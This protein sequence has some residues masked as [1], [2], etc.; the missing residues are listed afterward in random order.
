VLSAAG[1]RTARVDAQKGAD[2][3]EE[4]QDGAVRRLGASVLGLGYTAKSHAYGSAWYEHRP[5][6]GDG[7]FA[8]D[9]V[10]P[11][12]A[13]P[14]DEDEEAR[15]MVIR[16][17]CIF[18]GVSRAFFRERFGR[19]L[20]EH[21]ALA[22]GLSELESLGKISVSAETVVSRM[23]D[24]AERSVWLKALYSEKVIEGLL[25]LH[26]EEY[27][28]FVADEATLGSA[29]DEKAE[30]RARFL[31]YYRDAAARRASALS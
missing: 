7:V 21:P 24:A 12:F 28:R 13:L 18:G 31:I 22:A 16:H 14:T 25:T 26:A 23:S 6:P 8:T 19:D 30:T 11:F 17:L 3:P 1:Y 20:L 29:L 27:A 4:R 2:L 10:P 9:G 5:V 15:G